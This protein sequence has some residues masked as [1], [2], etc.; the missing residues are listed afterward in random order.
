VGDQYRNRVDADR[1]ATVKPLVR[2]D[3]GT[4]ARSRYMPGLRALLD[5]GGTAVDFPTGDRE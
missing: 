5:D 2:T 4:G 3:A 1:H